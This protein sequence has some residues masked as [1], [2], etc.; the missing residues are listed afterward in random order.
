[1]SKIKHTLIL[2]IILLTFI[3]YYFYW[4]NKSTKLSNKKTPRLETTQAKHSENHKKNRTKITKKRTK[5]DGITNKSLITYVNEFENDPVIEY[6]VLFRRHKT[7][8]EYFYY[9]ENSVT[10]KRPP[11]KTK[12]QQDFYEQA[13]KNCEKLNKN[14]PEYGLIT[15]IKQQRIENNKQEATTRFGVLLEPNKIEYTEEETLFIFKTIAQK[16][17]SLINSPVTYKTMQYKIDEMT[18]KVMQIIQ[19]T[20]VNYAS[21]ILH[22]AENYLACQLG[23]DCS[24]QSSMMYYYCRTE[25]NFCV[26]DFDELFNSRF[27]SAVK[28]D[29]LLVLPYIETIYQVD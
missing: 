5:H 12:Q 19:T 24:N 26:N 7:C 22:D 15:P 23:A 11:F 14:H 27:P 6:Q 17:P 25:A 29:V 4:N 16:Y 8:I 2:A 9:K 10:G 20:Q 28:T 21:R 3:S 18:P 1:M 13:T